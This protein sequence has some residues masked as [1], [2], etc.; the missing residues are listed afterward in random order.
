MSGGLKT[1]EMSV[2]DGEQ[3]SEQND[4]DRYLCD[5]WNDRAE[6][7]VQNELTDGHKSWNN[8]IRDRT[9]TQDS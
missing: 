1:C 9:W 5:D 3:Q 2:I 7:W 4:G 8:R 6:N